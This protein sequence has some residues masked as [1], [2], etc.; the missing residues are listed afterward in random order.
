LIQNKIKEAF[1]ENKEA[2]KVPFDGNLEQFLK[3][4][5]TQEYIEDVIRP[6]KIAKD[7]NR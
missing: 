4:H 2:I 7:R 1:E 6:Y 5:M 3:R